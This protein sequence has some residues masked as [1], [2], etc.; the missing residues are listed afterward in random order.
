MLALNGSNI[1]QVKSHNRQAILLQ[2]LH[3]PLSR[4]ELADTLGLS[5]M[6]VTNLINELL[7]EGWV[8]SNETSDSDTFSKRGR[9]RPRICMRINPQAG[10]V[11]GVQIGIGTYRVAQLDLLGLLINSIENN[12]DIQQAGENVLAEIGQTI[13]VLIDQAGLRH[14]KIVGIGVGASGLVDVAQGINI[15]APSLGWQNLPIA[16]L[17]SHQTNLPVVV[18]NN[19]RAMTLAEVY[20][21]QGREGQSL[22]FIFGRIGVA[23]GLAIQ[24]RVVRGA[25]FGAGEIGH[26]TILPSG[27]AQCRCGRYGCLETLVAQ[28]S[29]LQ[30]AGSLPVVAQAWADAKI[31]TTVEQL[32]TVFELARAGEA[33][34]VHEVEQVAHYLGI[35]LSNLVNTINPERMVLGGMYAQGADLFLPLLRERVAEVGFGGLGEQVHIEATTFGLDAGVIGAGSVALASL[36]Y[37]ADRLPNHSTIQQFNN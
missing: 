24:G 4:V 2:L 29:L 30:S 17:L 37:E 12:F 20:F 34:V 7:A 11:I 6:T 10:Y 3:H 26:T 35:A 18:E 32:E 1:V 33:Q 8:V 27:G 21:G 23:A 5:A 28:P 15:Y 13:K 22:A 16:A 9:G 25:Q 31:E 14:D 36:F 19:V